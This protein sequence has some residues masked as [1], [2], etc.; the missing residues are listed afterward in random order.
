MNSV[1]TTHTS[2]WF[3]GL[4]IHLWSYVDVYSFIYKSIWENT[5]NTTVI[6][7]CWTDTDGK[8][9]N[10]VFCKK[11]IKQIVGCAKKLDDM[12]EVERPL[13]AGCSIGHNS[14]QTKSLN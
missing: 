10:Q 1:K 12:T 7:F 2:Q 9:G 13:V 3:A 4:V 8:E 11:E 14:S 6:C 5:R